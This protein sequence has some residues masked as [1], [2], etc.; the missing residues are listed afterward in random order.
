M[1]PAV[2][3]TAGKWLLAGNWKWAVPPAI[4]AVAVIY[5]GTQR[6]NYLECKSNHAEGIAKADQKAR[7]FQA[8]DKAHADELVG[9]YAGEIAEL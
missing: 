2:A 9:Q 8:K 1:I 3:L 4:A 7:E 6:I 5:A